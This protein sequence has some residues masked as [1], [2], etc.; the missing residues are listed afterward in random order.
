MGR[1]V[2]RTIRTGLAVAAALAGAAEARAQLPTISIVDARVVE[3]SA[4]SW[5]LDLTV[6]LSASS[7]STVSATWSTVDGSAV[8]GEDFTSRAGPV[9]FDPGV[10]SQTLTVPIIGESVMAEWSPTLQM[11]EAFFVE[12]ASA[13]NATL[14]KSRATVTIV[15]DDRPLPGLQLVS[16][17]ADGNATQ[18]RVRLQWRVPPSYASGDPVDVRV[19]WNEGSACAAPAD[20]SASV[21]G[22]FLISNPPL[23]T[24]A[25]AVK[26]PGEAQV[27]EHLGR[28]LVKH[29][30]SLFAVYSPGGPTTERAVVSATPF[31]STPPN[32]VAWAYSTGG[33]APDYSAPTVGTEAVYIVSLDGLVHAMTRGE[34]GGA[35]PPL[36]N[37][38]ALGHPTHNR[39]PVVPLPHGPRLFVGTESGEVHAVDGQN[40][41][42][43]WS[44]SPWFNNTQLVPSTGGVQGTPAGI[45]T[46][47]AGQHDV[48]LVGTNNGTSG[49]RFF[50]LDPV[51][52]GNVSTYSDG[53]MGAARGMAAVDYPGNT[54]FFLTT[55]TTGTLWAFHLGAPGSPGLTPITSPVLYP[56]PFTSGASGS[57][58]VRNGRLYFGLANGDVVAHRLSDGQRSVVGL[59]SEVKGFVFPDRRNGDLYLSTSDSV[60]GVRDTLDPATPNLTLPWVVSDIPNPSIVLHW[61]NTNYLYVGGGD[62]RLYQIDVSS[63]TPQSTK[64]SVLLEAGSQIGAPSLDGPNGLVLVGS[65]TG[66]VYAVR[67]PLP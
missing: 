58:V 46:T 54:V 43:A 53:A 12:V 47:F 51:T 41:A 55:S 19:R 65:A 17:I 10:T 40:G 49:N 22:E 4:G 24:L 42:I 7:T 34:T 8:G 29:C 27:F 30:Y 33:A 50:M 18:G 66:V 52:G 59:G 16:A 32:G 23:P 13:T 62:G 64:K 15:D 28:P 20:V 57:P 39:S 21:T 25:A 56:V 1:K 26:Q 31:D 60:W 61:P 45:F 63:A 67:V 2:V 14:L 5:D 6:T 3:G 35:W 36:W 9:V 44:R 37:P 11:D 38:V 48:I